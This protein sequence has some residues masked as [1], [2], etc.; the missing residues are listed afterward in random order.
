M[1]EDEAALLDR[2]ETNEKQTEGIEQ[3]MQEL[4]RQR[5]PK[6][7][8]SKELSSKE[9]RIKKCM[10]EMPQEHHGSKEW[11]EM[12]S[13]HK[14]TSKGIKE[15][16][17]PLHEINAEIVALSKQAACREEEEELQKDRKPLEA[18]GQ[19]AGRLVPKLVIAY[20]PSCYLT[21]DCE[22]KLSESDT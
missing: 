2:E 13:D 22:L 16:L 8:R 11:K 1:D 9:K 21:V 10:K 18:D 5:D 3:E 15:V 4:F 14:K 6:E 17:E 12:N 7:Q 19:Y 20:H